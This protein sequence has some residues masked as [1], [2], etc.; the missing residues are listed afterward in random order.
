M[1]KGGRVR[2]LPFPFLVKGRQNGQIGVKNL[3][4]NVASNGVRFARAC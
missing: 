1:S 3:G 2:P 4:N